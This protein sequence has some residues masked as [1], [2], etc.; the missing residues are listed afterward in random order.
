MTKII[1]RSEDDAISLLS[2]CL[3][4]EIAFNLGELS[5][6]GWPAFNLHVIGPQ[7]HQSITPSIMSGFLDLQKEVYKA[8]ALAK[9]NTVS[10]KNLTKEERKKLEFTVDVED[11]SSNFDIN[12][13]DLLA[14]FIDQAA[15]KMEPTHIL[16][17]LLGMSL[18]YFGSN[19]FKSYLDQRQRS[20]EAEL[21]SSQQGELISALKY[22]SQ[23]ETKR[24]ELISSLVKTDYRLQNLESASYDAHT[25]ILKSLKNSQQAD[26]QGIEIDGD[27]AE[28]L[29]Q[30]ARR[31]S[32]DVR[33]DGKFK[34]L[35]VDA[36]NAAA[37][38]VTIQNCDSDE[39]IDA[40]V[41]DESLSTNNRLTLQDAEWSR[42]PVLLKIN[43]K[44]KGDEIHSAVIIDVQKLNR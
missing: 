32:E 8:Y 12:L 3:S 1:I 28:L 21:K 41:Q 29:S 33:I 5:F 2:K 43:A 34:L 10:T 27:V 18:L 23:E 38:K 19:A 22:L 26:V 4:K 15:S 42:T 37:F 24:A 9:Y 14:R 16:I 35:K 44:S 17:A 13:Q 7:Y 20:R 11:G 31:K 40:K 6:D 30:N 39:V 25:S 36:S